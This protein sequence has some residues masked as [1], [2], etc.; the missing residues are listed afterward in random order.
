MVALMFASAGCSRERLEA[1]APVAGKIHYDGKPLAEATVVFHRLE[2]EGRSL[3]TRTTAD[4]TF[5]VTTH[6]PNDGAPPGRYAVT[7]ELRDW[8]R[9]G[10]EAVRSGRNLLPPKYAD[11][12]TSG[13][14][15][16]VVDGDNQLPLWNL[17]SR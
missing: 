8:V 5:R 17:Q 15:C 6:Q 2:G 10:D 9:D 1:V 4:G 13:L 16:V 12:R 11:P 14:E 3:T 7:V